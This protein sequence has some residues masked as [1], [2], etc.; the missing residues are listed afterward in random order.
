[1]ETFIVKHAKITFTPSQTIEPLPPF[2]KD[3]GKSVTISGKIEMDAEQR[4]NM[5]VFWL[6]LAAEQEARRL[7]G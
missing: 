2:P 7:L 4:R 6:W 5:M 3:F 1:M